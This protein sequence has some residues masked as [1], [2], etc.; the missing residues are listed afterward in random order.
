VTVAG[1]GKLQ[2]GGLCKAVRIKCQG[3]EIVADFHILPFGGCQM[4]FGVD[5][6][7]ILDEMTLSFKEQRVKITKEGRTWEFTG[8]QS[9]ALEL[10]L[11]E[12]MDRTMD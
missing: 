9:N 5:W 10:V 4:V 7:Q 11:A 6:L 12:L 3:V 2:S 8:I 1:G